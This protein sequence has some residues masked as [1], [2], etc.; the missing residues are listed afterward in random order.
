LLISARGTRKD[1]TISV[2]VDR[3]TMAGIALFGDM[4]TLIAGNMALKNQIK[5]TGANSG[6]QPST[7]SSPREEFRR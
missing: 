6:Q 7:C 4:G 1:F 5:A 2:E 3:T